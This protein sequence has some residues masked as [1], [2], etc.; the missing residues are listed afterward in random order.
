MDN[1]NI[2]LMK[3][4]LFILIEDKNWQ[5]AE[6]YAEKILDIDPKNVDAY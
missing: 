4:R 6:E 2:S 1:T 5:K 3:E